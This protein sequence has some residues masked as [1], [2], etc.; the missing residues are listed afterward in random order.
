[1][2]QLVERLQQLQP[3]LIVL[4][5]TGGLEVPIAAALA[6]AGLAVAVVNPRQVRDSPERRAGW[7]RPIL[8]MLACW[9]ISPKPF[10]PSP[11]PLPDAATQQLTALLT[12][13]RQV[14]EMLTAQKNRLPRT[15]PVVRPRLQ[16]HIT[17]LEQELSALNSDLDQAL[18]NSPV[19]CAQE[20]LLR[21]VPVGPVAA[22]TLLAELPELGTLN[23]KQIAALVGV[24]PL[25]QDSGKHRGQ[26]RVWGGRCGC[27]APC[28]WRPWSLRASMR[29]SGRSTNACW[30]PASPARWP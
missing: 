21:S 7:R 15:L 27:G 30:P 2:R 5:A 25:N 10:T 26:R 19:W 12:R 16:E 1:M 4:E 28:I 8:S 29:S 24:A 9:P 22:R 23:R 6:A 11:R 14:V 13:R 18:R 3:E 20:E 17:W